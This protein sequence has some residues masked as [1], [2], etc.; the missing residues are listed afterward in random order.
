MTSGLYVLVSSLL[1]DLLKFDHQSA[2][3]VWHT[4]SVNYGVLNQIWICKME[5]TKNVTLVKFTIGL[6]LKLGF[7]LIWAS[8]SVCLLNNQW[9][10][11]FP[12]YLKISENK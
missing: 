4:P 2:L 11:N 1:K 7:D 10:I 12:Y 5:W 3:L 6:N 8:G 9:L